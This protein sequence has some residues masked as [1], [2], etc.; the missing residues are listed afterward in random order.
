MTCTYSH[1]S[2]KSKDMSTPIWPP[3]IP[4]DPSR[5]PCPSSQ[6]PPNTCTTSTTVATA[7]RSTAII[8]SDLAL[9]FVCRPR[10]QY[11]HTVAFVPTIK[12][13]LCALSDVGWPYPG[14]RRKSWPLHYSPSFRESGC[15]DNSFPSWRCGM[16]SSAAQRHWRP[17]G[18]QMQC[19]QLNDLIV[20]TDGP[21]RRSCRPLRRLWSMRSSLR[22]RPSWYTRAMGDCVEKDGPAQAQC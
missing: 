4:S 6:C 14:R 19:C 18:P 5:P 9:A 8:Y 11:P 15:A 12:A 16:P 21:V 7:A 17:C 3:L 20:D 1:P 2:P 13:T 22:A 10:A